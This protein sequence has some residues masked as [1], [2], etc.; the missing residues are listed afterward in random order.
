MQHACV[1]PSR[2]RYLPFHS[3]L[4]HLHIVRISKRS[5]I[6]KHSLAIH[7]MKL[8]A[9]VF[10]RG[11]PLL[12]IDHQNEFNKRPPTVRIHDH[13][14]GFVIACLSSPLRLLALHSMDSNDSS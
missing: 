5:T 2:Q 3:R 13:V 8:E 6:K 12:F 9:T 10:V 11:G 4:E 14:P 7:I 1:Q